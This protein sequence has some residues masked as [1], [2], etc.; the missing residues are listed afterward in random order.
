MP[1]FTSSLL[2]SLLAAIALAD[3]PVQARDY[4]NCPGA[5]FVD[6]GRSGCCVGGKVDPPFLSVCEG[7]PICQGPT[8]TTW[9]QTPLSC[10]TIVTDGPDYDAQVS[11]A[12]ASLQASGTN[13]VTRLDGGAVATT[14]APAPG[15][16]G[17]SGSGAA[18]TASGSGS[19]SGSGSGSGTGSETSSGG[20]TAETSQAAAAELAAR[21]GLGGGAF[22][23]AAAAAML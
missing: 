20:A 5:Y 2:T 23:A 6:S 9:T 18:P 19:N 10:A 14:A 13:F 3:D 22:L 21:M 11:S 1:S 4:K 15:Q 17:S 8:T 7:W 12:S 16:S